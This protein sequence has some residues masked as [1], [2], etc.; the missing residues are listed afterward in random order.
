LPIGTSVTKPFSPIMGPNKLERLS[1][2]SLF[3]LL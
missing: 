2:A 3:S 1:L